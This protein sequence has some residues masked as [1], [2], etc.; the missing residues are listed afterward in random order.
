MKDQEIVAYFKIFK[1]SK[2]NFIQM[3]CG[4]GQLQLRSNSRTRKKTLAWMH[5]KAYVTEVEF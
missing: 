2:A 1:I 3:P 5:G 4:N